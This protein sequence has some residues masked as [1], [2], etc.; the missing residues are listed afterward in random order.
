[1]KDIDFNNIKLDKEEQWIEDHLEEYEP[2]PSWMR[3]ALIEA[4][5]KPPIIEYSDKPNKKVITLR[6]I[7][8]DIKALKDK[9]LQEGLPYQ[10]MIT[11]IIHKYLTGALVDINEARKLIKL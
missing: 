5:N 7:D 11:S 2:S 1:M 10:T 6:L 8:K 9:A 3:E 4:A